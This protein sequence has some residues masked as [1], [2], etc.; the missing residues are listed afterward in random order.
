MSC[1]LTTVRHTVQYPKWHDRLPCVPEF[2]LQEAEIQ[3]YGRE[4]T[5][6]QVNVIMD[7]LHK[8]LNNDAQKLEHKEGQRE[9]LCS[10]KA[11]H[12]CPPLCYEQVAEPDLQ[13][14]DRA[15]DILFEEVLRQIEYETNR[16]I[17]PSLN[18]KTGG[19]ADDQKSAQ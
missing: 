11:S 16:N 15:Y 18:L 8:S 9:L 1:L 17:R 6:D 3:G 4:F 19:G 5:I 7:I 13:A 12:R 14:I 10:N 2:E